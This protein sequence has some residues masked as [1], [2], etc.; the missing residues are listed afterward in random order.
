MAE[1]YYNISYGPGMEGIVNY[2]N[3]ITNGMF[4]ALF[5]IFIFIV[6][7]YTLSKS[8]WKMNSVLTY[9]FL[10]TFITSMIMR[11]FMR[12]NPLIMYVSIV[13]LAISVFVGFWTKQ[14]R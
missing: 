6:T 13:G 9:S 7:T 2:V 4:S 3:E 14:S 5:I 1:G 11:L 10:L 8:E 12:V